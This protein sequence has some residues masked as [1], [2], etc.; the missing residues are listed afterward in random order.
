MCI[1]GYL[2]LSPTNI[3]QL[4]NEIKHRTDHMV[5][6]R[7]DEEI[8]QATEFLY[9]YRILMEHWSMFWF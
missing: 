2:M 8:L 9:K 1:L 3:S 7:A 6:I 4:K 5:I